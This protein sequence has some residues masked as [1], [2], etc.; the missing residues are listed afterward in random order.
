M[1]DET[2]VSYALKTDEL[3]L[4]SDLH[5]S[6]ASLNSQTAINSLNDSLEYILRTAT[7]SI[8]PYKWSSNSHL[9]SKP[10]SL[11]TTHQHLKQL[12]GVI[13]ALRKSHRDKN[14]WPSQK[15]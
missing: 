11:V 15:E 12:N 13:L 8:I 1:T 9:D 6:S 3:I 10:K 4:K 2:W 14:I 7:N 5:R